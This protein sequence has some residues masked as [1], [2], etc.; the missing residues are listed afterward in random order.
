MLKE[1][2]EEGYTHYLSII[3][4]LEMYKKIWWR[5]NGGVYHGD[6]NIGELHVNDWQRIYALTEKYENQL[7]LII[8]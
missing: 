3:S 7:E 6:V 5:G 8:I 4:D 1:F 2:F